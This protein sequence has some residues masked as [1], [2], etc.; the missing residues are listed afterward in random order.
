MRLQ[1][2][3]SRRYE[4]TG[5]GRAGF[6]ACCRDAGAA[7]VGVGG[8]AAAWRAAAALALAVALWKRERGTSEEEVEDVKEDEEEEEV[9]LLRDVGCAAMRA[10]A[11]LRAAAASAA[12]TAGTIEGISSGCCLEACGW[13]GPAATR[14]P[15]GPI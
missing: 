1:R 5:A 3:S 12:A 4:G 7:C 6:L 14:R 11:A 15:G 10:G 2:T 9:L 8:P 13:R